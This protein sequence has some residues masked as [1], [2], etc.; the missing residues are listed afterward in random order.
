MQFRLREGLLL[1]AVFLSTACSETDFCQY[2]TVDEAKSFD[3]AI[4]QTE[5]RQTEA[6]LYCVY[7]SADSD[8]LFLSLDRAFGSTPEQ[9][10]R[11]LAKNAPERS[12]K[13][14]SL[15]GEDYTAAAL[16][17]GDSDI[18]EL[19][20]LVAQNAHF[21][22]AVRA[23]RVASDEPVKLQHLQQIVDRVMSRL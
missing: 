20:F 15:P 22:V 19:D 11:V 21:S 13:I 18:L 9:F 12:Q 6:V 10:L 8:R 5:M 2:L 16:F 7:K 1:A 4:N 3:P 23:P 14:V 17:L